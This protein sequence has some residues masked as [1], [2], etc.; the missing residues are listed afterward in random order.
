M[1]DP[2]VSSGRL[3]YAAPDSLL[4]KFDRPKGEYVMMR[5]D[6]FFMKK[7]GKEPVHRRIDADERGQGL[8]MLVDLFRD[9]AAGFKNRYEVRMLADTSELKVILTPK[10]GD[11]DEP[12]RI[13][14]RLLLPGLE[15]RSVLV[16]YGENQSILYEFIDPVRNKTIRAEIFQDPEARP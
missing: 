10:D 9:G 2:I 8:G 6:D 16:R 5:G 12:G 3:Y 14:N 13:E 7:S 1:R 11:E 15:I 4:I